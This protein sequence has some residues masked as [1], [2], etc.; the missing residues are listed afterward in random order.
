[1]GGTG[2]VRT[3]SWGEPIEGAQVRVWLRNNNGGWAMGDAG[4]TDKNGLYSVPVP[5]DRA[6]MAVV[7][8]KEHL[9]ATANDAYSYGQRG[10]PVP[11]E[12]IAF[13]TDRSLYRPGQTIH[14]KGIVMRVDQGNDSYEAVA[15]RAVT[16]RFQDP[17][18]KEIARLQTKSNDYGSIS[19]TFTAPRDRLMGRMHVVGENVSGV[20][21][22]NVEEYKRPKFKVEVEAPK[23]AF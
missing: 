16:V 14:F 4:K 18:G 8:H 10:Q 7:T 5:R 12:S 17:N 11:H 21:S 20:A 1:G 6:H 13:F 22:F 19:G 3:A 2:E 9:L 23:D 15:N